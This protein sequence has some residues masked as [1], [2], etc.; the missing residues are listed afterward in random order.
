[1]DSSDNED[2]LSAGKVQ[3]SNTKTN[4]KDGILKKMYHST[5][6]GLTKMAL[7]QT[8][9]QA[10][11]VPAMDL[12]SLEESP[13]IDGEEVKKNVRENNLMKSQAFTDKGGIFPAES[14]VIGLKDEGFDTVSESSMASEF[15]KVPISSLSSRELQ[16]M[17]EVDENLLVKEVDD[18]N[19]DEGSENNTS[20]MITEV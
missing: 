20:I 8:P 6:G 16:K 17:L 18:A 15:S 1:M 7:S 12:N 10:S 13:R 4:P 19:A 2:V 9:K 3:N 11:R 14:M 5:E